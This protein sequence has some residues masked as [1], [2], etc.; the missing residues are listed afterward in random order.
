MLRIRVPTKWG[1]EFLRLITFS[2]MFPSTLYALL[3][4]RFQNLGLVLKPG[5]SCT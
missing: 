4:F 5:R 1:E 3:A 2:E